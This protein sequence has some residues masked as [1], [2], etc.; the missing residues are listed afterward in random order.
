MEMKVLLKKGNLKPIKMKKH[1]LAQIEATANAIKDH[2][3]PK[4]LLATEFSFHFTIPPSSNY[5][6]K[7]EKNAIGDWI[8][9]NAEGVDD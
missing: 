3:I 6:A 7:Y 1:P 4:D 2:F 8:L 9:I 5:R